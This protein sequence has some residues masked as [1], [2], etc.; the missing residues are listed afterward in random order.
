MWH[1]IYEPENT[2]KENTMKFLGIV[3]IVAGVLMIFF[4]TFSQKDHQSLNST[5]LLANTAGS[6]KSVNATL[7]AGGIAAFCGLI[8]IM[9]SRK[10]R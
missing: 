7:Y 10:K 6:T 1:D 4:T 3:L 5:Q 8:V 2:E 9:A